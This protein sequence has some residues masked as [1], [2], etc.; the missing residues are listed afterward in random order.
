MSVV[1]FNYVDVQPIIRKGRKA[2]KEFVVGIFE[3]ESKPLKELNYI[4][5]S[6]DY[7][8]EMNQSFLKHDH[9]TDIITFDLS[10]GN[11]T[12]GEI[13]IS[14]DRVRENSITHGTSVRREVLRVIFHGALHLIGY[15]DKKKSEI[16]IMRDKEEYYLRL[17]G[18]E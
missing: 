12:I 3:L 4:F 14:S 17:F 8:L 6:D 10:E 7:L 13:Y 16:T 1:R 2:V 15:K 18:D 5:C 9:Y 11:E